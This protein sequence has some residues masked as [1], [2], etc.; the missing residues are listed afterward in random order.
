MGNSAHAGVSHDAILA[1]VQLVRD[2]VPGLTGSG[3]V[4]LDRI[5]LQLTAVD[6]LRR[7]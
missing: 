2:A 3:Y 5:L 4:E 6:Q 1:A 7:A